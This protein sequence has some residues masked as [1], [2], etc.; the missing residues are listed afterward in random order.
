[1][2]VPT[3]S[4]AA[5]TAFQAFVQQVKSD[6]DALTPAVPLAMVS[7][8]ASVNPTQANTANLSVNIPMPAI[9]LAPSGP[10][11][12]VPITASWSMTLS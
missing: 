11:T 5:Q 1:M 7:C 12:M 6:L 10:A 9:Q 2:T 8:N 4:A 3:L